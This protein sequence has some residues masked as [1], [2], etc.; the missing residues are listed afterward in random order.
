MIRK[1]MIAMLLAGG[2][3][4]RLGILTDSVAKSAIP[5]GGK[6]RV[7][8]FPLS[9]CINSGIDTVGVVTRYRPVRLNSHIGIG[10]S[11]DMDKSYGGVTVLPTFD[12]K[13]DGLIIGTGEAIYRNY[14]YMLQYHPEYVLIA[15]GD[16]LCKMDYEIMLD[17]MKAM[18][19]DVAVCAIPAKEGIEGIE[20]NLF[21]TDPYG[22]ILSPGETAADSRPY[23]FT[24]IYI[25]RWTVLKEALLALKDN[26]MCDLKTDVLPY[27]ME[28]G[29]TLC[30]YEFTGYYEKLYSPAAYWKANMELLYEDRG[31]G[32]NLDEHFWK[33]YTNGEENAPVYLSDDAE[34]SNCIIG[35]GADIQGRVIDSVIGSGVTVEPGAVIRNSVIMQ[36]AY[37]GS[38]VMID[39]AIICE[40]AGIGENTV[41]G[42]G[43]FAP[44]KLDPALYNTDLAIIG[45][46]AVIPSDVKIGRNTVIS[47]MTDDSDYPNGILE[48]GCAVVP[49][50]KEGDNA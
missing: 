38:G 8:D 50:Q 1:E 5:F 7:I 17:F 36:E 45:E 4:S 35:E 19:A 44:S 37:I 42:T 24:G 26:P 47:G 32:L 43:E 25:F 40:G 11:W 21:Y 20:R 2:K 9:N 13:A 14:E 29:N 23:V 48:S 12:E 34:I 3:G 18:N 31:P 30:A 6:Y 49:V 22:Y 16:H 15:P 10:T 46:N 28:S 41:I 33:I 27:C 39:R